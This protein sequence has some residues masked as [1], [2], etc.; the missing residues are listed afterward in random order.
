MLIVSIL[1]SIILSLGMVKLLNYHNNNSIDLK[2]GIN[3]GLLVIAFLLFL[4][5]YLLL[6]LIFN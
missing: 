4:P 6:R 3:I 5:I 1:I 2:Y